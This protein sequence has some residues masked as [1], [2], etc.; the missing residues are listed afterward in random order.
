MSVNELQLNNIF[1]FEVVRMKTINSNES[2]QGQK[3]RFIAMS[4]TIPNVQ[5]IAEWLATV[6]VPAEY[7]RLFY[8]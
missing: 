8:S 6:K 2:L 7:F 5:D 1:T 4:A 3:M